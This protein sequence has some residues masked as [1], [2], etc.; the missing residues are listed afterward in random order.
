M[1]LEYFQAIKGIVTFSFNVQ[2]SFFGQTISINAETLG[3]SQC[4]IIFHGLRGSE[5]LSMEL[6][7]KKRILSNHISR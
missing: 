3:P 5:I 6:K 4:H 7:K 1:L 2:R